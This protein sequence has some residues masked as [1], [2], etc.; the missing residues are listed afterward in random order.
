MLYEE[1]QFLEALYR[2]YFPKLLLYAKT[3]L[4]DTDRAQDVVQDT[5]HE[6]IR[7]ID[8]LTNHKNPGGWLME[9]LKNKIRDSERARRRFISRFISLDSDIVENIIPSNQSLDDQLEQDDTWV[10]QTIEDALTPEENK[11]LKRLA[12]DK[13][14]HLE[15]A[16][17][18]DITVY[19]SE[20][21]FQRIKE[22]LYKLFPERRKH[23]KK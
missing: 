9:T 15:V 5:F 3:V 14:S 6:A 10:R 21:R 4:Q 16:K 8:T 19:A 17:E 11:L 23:K 2:D 13:A 12:F 1:N 22:K 20:K 7:H 18:F